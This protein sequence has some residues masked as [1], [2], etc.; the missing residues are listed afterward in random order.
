MAASVH[1]VDPQPLDMTSLLGA[2]KVLSAGPGEAAGS[3][4]V[5]Q[6]HKGGEPPGGVF[7]GLRSSLK[8]LREHE[9]RQARSMFVGQG[10]K[11]LPNLTGHCATLALVRH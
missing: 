8:T 4:L 2:G 9:R 3:L 10:F 11:P 5:N 6:R 7:L 1:G